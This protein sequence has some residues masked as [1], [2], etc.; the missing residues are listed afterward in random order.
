M[1]ELPATRCVQ[2]EWMTYYRY[3][4]YRHSYITIFFQKNS[5]KPSKQRPLYPTGESELNRDS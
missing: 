2:V 3:L 5:L 4:F 1:V